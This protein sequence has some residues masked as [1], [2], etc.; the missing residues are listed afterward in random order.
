[1]QAAGCEFES[2]LIHMQP[3][4]R[5]RQ[6]EQKLSNQKFVLREQQRALQARNRQLDAMHWVWC[7]GGCLG[8]IHRFPDEDGVFRHAALNEAVVRE[9]ERN[10]KRLRSWWMNY[11]YRVASTNL[12]NRRYFYLERQAKYG[13]R[14]LRWFYRW[15]F[16]RCE[17]P[18]WPSV[19]DKENAGL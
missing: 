9:A 3:E 5:I 15:R 4:E 2:R 7:D 18:I 8:G 6:L 14:W 12:E 19:Y 11:Q 10:T 16:S 13:A 17:K 1:M